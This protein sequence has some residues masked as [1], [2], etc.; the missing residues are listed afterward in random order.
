MHRKARLSLPPTKPASAPLVILLWTSPTAIR[1][2]VFSLP[3]DDARRQVLRLLPYRRRHCA[4]CPH[5]LCGP[6]ALPVTV[7]L[8]TTLVIRFQ[9][10]A[11]Q[12][13]DAI[14][15]YCKVTEEPLG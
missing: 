7:A 10:F 4:G 12:R 14:N 2:A 8:L 13:F 11:E 15:L 6:C 3:E 9:S 5:P 1:L